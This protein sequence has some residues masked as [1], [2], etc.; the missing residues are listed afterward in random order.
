VAGPEAMHSRLAKFVD[1]KCNSPYETQRVCEVLTRIGIADMAALTAL[2]VTA[3]EDGVRKQRPTDEMW[4]T[5][6]AV[7]VYEAARAEVAR[8]KASRCRIPSSPMRGKAS[9]EAMSPAVASNGVMDS[10][11]EEVKRMRLH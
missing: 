8:T 9:V 4:V 5:A 7:R 2:D 3:L 6:H 11:E 1:D 10:V